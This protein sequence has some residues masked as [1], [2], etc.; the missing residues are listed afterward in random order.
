MLGQLYD[1]GQGVAQDYTE[2]HMW[3]NPA[4]SRTNGDD[5]K[6]YA[7]AREAVA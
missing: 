2:A 1:E 4:A 5:Q 3:F 7:D 6:K